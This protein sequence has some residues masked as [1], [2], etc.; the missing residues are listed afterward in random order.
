M[1]VVAL[2]G[3][4]TSVANANR[5]AAVSIADVR[6]AVRSAVNAAMRQSV[7]SPHL[8]LRRGAAFVAKG[9]FRS[10][11]ACVENL[12]EVKEADIGKLA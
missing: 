12:I 9:G 6:W 2:G 3:A 10:F 1:T 4:A 7:P 5:I 8:P 11:A